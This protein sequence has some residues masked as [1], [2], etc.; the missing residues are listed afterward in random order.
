[1]ACAAGGAVALAESIYKW[2]CQH[3]C[4]YAYR[5][6][7]VSPFKHAQARDAYERMFLNAAK[8]G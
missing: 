8:G 4:V 3:V 7:H 5:L 1:M 2:P 6:R